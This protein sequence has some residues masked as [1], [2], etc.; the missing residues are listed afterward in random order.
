MGHRLTVNAMDVMGFP[1]GDDSMI[2][3]KIIF[4]SQKELRC[5]SQLLKIEGKCEMDFLQQVP[6][7]YPVMRKPWSCFVLFTICPLKSNYEFT[8]Y[9]LLAARSRLRP[10]TLH[11]YSFNKQNWLITIITSNIYFFYIIVISIRISDCFELKNTTNVDISY[12]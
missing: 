11:D 6:S 3:I 8:K 12:L 10:L 9:C 1:P 7:I 4:I 5:V 2:L